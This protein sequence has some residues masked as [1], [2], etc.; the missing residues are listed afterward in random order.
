MSITREDVLKMDVKSIFAAVKD[1]K[2]SSDM[3]S[4]LRDRQVAAYVSEKMLEAQNATANREAEVDSQL[5]RVVPPSTEELAAEAQ[6]MAATPAVP[7][8]AVVEPTP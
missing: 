8:E 2:T 5:N 3:Q 6:A 4:L 7:V 1:P